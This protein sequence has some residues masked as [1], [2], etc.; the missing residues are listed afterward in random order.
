MYKSNRIFQAI[1]FNHI[2]MGLE[3][4]WIDELNENL[5]EETKRYIDVGD[6][7]LRILAEI[8]KE[9]Y[10]EAKQLDDL[11]RIINCKLYDQNLMLSKIAKYLD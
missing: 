8:I 2:I 11:D 9:S 3:L 6:Y 5:S 10:S 7:D 1:K 4:A